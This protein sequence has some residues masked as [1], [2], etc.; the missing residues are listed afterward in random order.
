M[1]NMLPSPNATGSGWAVAHKK[2]LA[3]VEDL[4]I[5]ELVNMTTGSGISSR[6]V[7]NTG[8]VTRKGFPGLCLQDGPV[9]VR[10]ADFTSAFTAG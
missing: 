10:T 7:G 4:T 2:A 8:A 5:E 9:G 3:F 1:K 6:C